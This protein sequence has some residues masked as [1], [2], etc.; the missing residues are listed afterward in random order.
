[1]LLYIHI[2]NRKKFIIKQT[3]DFCVLIIFIE[4]TSNDT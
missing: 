2:K 4:Q 3:A 1:M